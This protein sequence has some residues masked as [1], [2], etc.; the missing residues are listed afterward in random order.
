MAVAGW[1]FKT[2]EEHAA[3]WPRTMRPDQLAALQRPYVRGGIESRPGRWFTEAL[4][5]AIESGCASG[6]LPN[7]ATTSR[8]TPPANSLQRTRISLADSR[9]NRYATN[10]WSAR[11]FPQP[12]PAPSPTL[13]DVTVYQVTA[14]AF[15]EWLAAQ[16]ETPSQHITAWVEASKSAHAVIEPPEGWKLQSSYGLLRVDGSPTGRLAR[17]ADVVLWLMHKRELPCAVAVDL[18][19]DSIEHN[20]GGALLYLLDERGYAKALPPEH[21]FFY[22]PVV[23][24]W[25][26]QPKPGTDNCGLPGAVKNMRDYWGQGSLSDT[27]ETLGQHMLDPLAIRL[28]K[29]FEL[30]GYGRLP[31]VDANQKVDQITEPTNRGEPVAT[32]AAK[33]LQRRA[34][35]DAA[36]LAAIK[37]VDL[38]HMALPKNPAGKPGVKA[39]IRDAVKNNPLFTGGTVFDKAWERLHKQGDIATATDPV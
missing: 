4:M 5:K 19:C 16:G 31:V 11:D 18:V 26:D 29:A 36:I 23:S 32:I 34:A 17:L 38:D 25:E 12:A 27:V 1:H 6:A 20:A 21:S 35:Q 9:R 13:K 24:F 15:A 39:A 2:K 37:A 22:I 30:W 8:Q 28:D 33:P 3:G 14:P 7:S 10:E